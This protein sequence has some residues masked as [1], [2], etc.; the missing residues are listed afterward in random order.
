MLELGCGTG[1]GLIPLA[2]AGYRTIG[3]DH[4]LSMLKFLR[5]RMDDP[6]RFTP[7]LAVADMCKFHLSTEYP[8][9][10]LPCNTYST[11][12]NDQR[13]ACLG[14]VRRHLKPG[15]IFTVSLPG[16]DLL[17][18]L[19]ARSAPQIEDEFIHPH[20]HNPVQ[21]SSTWQRTKNS[22]KVTWVYDHLFPDGRVEHVVVDTVHQLTSLE[23][24]IGEIEHAGIKVMEVYGDFDRSTYAADSPHLIILTSH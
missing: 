20:T 23:T 9:I 13:M 4:D 21:V 5:D 12:S 19:P 3:L 17:Q 16:P 10:I 8:L 2:Q 15:G 24:Y 7:L 18:R 11:L 22:F 6:V 14:C 1:R